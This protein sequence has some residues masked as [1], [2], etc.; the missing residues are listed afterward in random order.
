MHEHRPIQNDK[1][2][3]LTSK[4]R[5]D[6][7]SHPF[8]KELARTGILVNCITPAA[9]ET[10]LFRQMTEA[11]VR[12]MLSKIPMGRFGRIEEVAAMTAWLCS[13]ECSFT[14]GGVFDLSGGR[15]TY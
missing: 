5:S 12:F 10:D 11:H 4:N 2:Y 3:R 14:T 15:A 13:E 1:R 6:P 9:V 7:F 8:P